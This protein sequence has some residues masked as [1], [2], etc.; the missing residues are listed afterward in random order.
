VLKLGICANP[1]GCAPAG[2]VCGPGAHDCCAGEESCLPTS[3]GVLRCF[4]SGDTT[5]CIADQQPC[6]FGDQCC[7]GI[8]APEPV[9]GDLICSPQCLE[10]NIACTTNRDCCSGF[11]DPS[12]LTCRRSSVCPARLMRS[13]VLQSVLRASAVPA[14]EKQ[15][16]P[17]HVCLLFRAH[18]LCIF[19]SEK[20]Y[21]SNIMI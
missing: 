2:E 3:I 13:A 5:Q 8:C 6:A 10:L 15:E 19:N 14:V 20:H 11:C 1:P 12:T 16:N 4:G 7:S 21:A 9:T 17:H 18:I